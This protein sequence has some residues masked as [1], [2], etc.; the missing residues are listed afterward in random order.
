MLMPSTTVNHNFIWRMRGLLLAL[1]LIGH[2]A[3]FLPSRGFSRV[4]PIRA[5]RRTVLKAA[6]GESLSHV[7]T[8]GTVNSAYD[9]IRQLRLACATAKQQLQRR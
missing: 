4:A 2:A 1:A 6:E 9:L 8:F 3:A 7:P 5:S